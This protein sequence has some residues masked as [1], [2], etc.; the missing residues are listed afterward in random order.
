MQLLSN[1]VNKI[2][3]EAIRPDI[4]ESTEVGRNSKTNPNEFNIY[5]KG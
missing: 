2:D 1:L 4:K 3:T 5:E